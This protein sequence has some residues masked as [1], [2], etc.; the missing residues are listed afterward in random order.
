VCASCK[1]DANSFASVKKVYDTLSPPSDLFLLGS[2][3]SVFFSFAHFDFGKL[4]RKR[5]YIF[6]PHWYWHY[7]RL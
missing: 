2:F 7:F 5:W 1:E 3:V 4:M 6:H